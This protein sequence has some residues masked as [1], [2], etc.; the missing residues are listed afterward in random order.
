MSER[1]AKI[2]SSNDMMEYQIGISERLPLRQQDEQS[3]S[4]D[5]FSSNYDVNEA[6]PMQFSPFNNSRDDANLSRIFGNSDPEPMH[7]VSNEPIINPKSLE[8]DTQYLFFKSTVLKETRVSNGA[9]ENEVFEYR[10][11]R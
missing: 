1:E 4:S 5:H 7:D 8:S 11:I 9:T 3:S 10:D 2:R 6:N